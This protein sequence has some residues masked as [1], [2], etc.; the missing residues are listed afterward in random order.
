MSDHNMGYGQSDVMARLFPDEVKTGSARKQQ[1]SRDSLRMSSA[2]QVKLS[3]KKS[4][5]PVS[6]DEDYGPG[7]HGKLE[8]KK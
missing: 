2:S 5:W 3:K 6:Q 8:E 4:H 1:K 7:E